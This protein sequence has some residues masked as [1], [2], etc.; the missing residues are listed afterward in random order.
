MTDPFRNKKPNI[1]KLLDYGF[2]NNNNKYTYT[3]DLCDQGMTLIA[4][5]DGNAVNVNIYDVASGE[6]YI[7]HLTDAQGSFVGRVRSEYEAFLL[8]V[9]EKCF[10][11]EIFKSP[12]T[13]RVISYIRERYGTELEFLWKETPNNGVMRRADTGKW[14]GVIMTIPR[15]RLGF[16]S[17]E[18]TEV[19]NL[20]T[21]TSADIVDG[22]RYFPGWHMN[23]KYWITV[24][25]DD[26][27]S[28]SELFEMV[29]RSYYSV[30]KK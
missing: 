11:G 24:I 12:Q 2:K 4:E 15:D 17:K 1:G 13:K 8:D 30:K 5:L 16:D 21:D 27:V 22:E 23:K 20:H 3:A 7:L 25:L 18:L 10:D 19:M 26:R 9:S 29:D 14:Y 28:D 6:E